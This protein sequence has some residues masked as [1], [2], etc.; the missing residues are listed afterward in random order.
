MIIVVDV[1]YSEHG[2]NAAAVCFKDWESE[3][4]LDV[5]STVLQSTPPYVPGEFYKRE[6]PCIAAVL[7]DYDLLKTQAIIIDGYVT[8]NANGK[9]GLGGYL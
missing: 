2:A 7:K 1:Y 5:K 3:E 4:V 6:L 9:L 8:L